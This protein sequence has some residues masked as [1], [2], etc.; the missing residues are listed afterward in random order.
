[1]AVAQPIIFRVC[2]R[3]LGKGRPCLGGRDSSSGLI[4]CSA[5]DSKISMTSCLKVPLTL[6]REVGWGFCLERHRPP[7]QRK[8]RL[9]HPAGH[10]TASSQ[11]FRIAS[12]RISLAG[13]SH[14]ARPSVVQAAGK[15]SLQDDDNDSHRGLTEKTSD[16]KRRVLW[17]SNRRCY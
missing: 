6:P 3:A 9:A 15:C 13:C 8:R 5:N 14:M 16:C 4:D 7:E 2:H 11:T 12:S 10:F 1:M 17:G